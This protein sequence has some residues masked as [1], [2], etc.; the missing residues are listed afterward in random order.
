[1]KSDGSISTSTSARN[2]TRFPSC[3]DSTRTN[4][5]THALGSMP[6][7]SGESGSRRPDSE[8]V[9]CRLPRQK[10]SRTWLLLAFRGEALPNTLA[11]Y[12]TA[13]ISSFERRTRTK[14]AVADFG[15]V[16][17]RSPRSVLF[18]CLPRAGWV[19]GGVRSTSGS[20]LQSGFSG[21]H[22]AVQDRAT[23]GVSG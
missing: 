3:S 21:I 8:A 12:P 10:Q 4:L 9:S 2:L 18:L 1:M 14:L 7:D 5:T 11:V 15:P 16:A 6:I 22:S 19:L 20:V 13:R 17:V 23:L